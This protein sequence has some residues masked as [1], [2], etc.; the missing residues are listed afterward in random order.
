MARRWTHPIRST[1]H[2]WRVVR[3][4]L[5]WQYLRRQKRF[6]LLLLVVLPVG[7]IAYIPVI[8]L[9]RAMVDHGI[10][11]QTVPLS[12]YL[13][14]IVGLAILA[15]FFVFALTQ[16][17]A[18]VAYQLEYD[19]RTDLYH[20]IQT[21]EVRELDEIAGGQLITRS[22]SDLQIV[23]SIMNLL[24]VALA[25][26]PA[27]FGIGVY[28]F[29][30]SPPLAI[31][32]LLPVP[33]MIKLLRTIRPR[34]AALSWAELNE[35]AEVTT[36]VDEPVRGIRVVKA[37]GRE[38]E[39][40][41]KVAAVSLR[42]YRYTM[43]R[44]RL[45]ARFNLPV[46]ALPVLTQALLLYVG[47]RL[48]GDDHITLGTFL[49]AF[50]L[51]TFTTQLGSGLDGLISTWQYFRSAQD[52]L[53]EVI[54]MGGVSVAA[55]AATAP[56]VAAPAVGD[57]PGITLDDVDV[58][59]DGRLVL[60]GL[61]LHAAPGEVVAV[62]GPP[63]SGKS[64][65]AALACG[66][67]RP[68]H[69]HVLVDG[70]DLEQLDAAHLRQAIRIVGEEPFLFADTLAENLLLG[71]DGDEA[72]LHA[73]LTA[74]AADDVV[75][76]VDGGLDGVLG[77]R[78]LTLSGGQR[79]RVALARALVSPPRVLV[80]DD[81]FSAVNPSL[82][83]EI[84]AHVRTR[85]RR[86]PRCCSSPAAGCRRT[87]PIASCTCHRPPSCSIADAV[88]E[89]AT[90]AE[91]F[92]EVADVSVPSLVPSFTSVAR[93]DLESVDVTT[94][95]PPVPDAAASADHPVGGWEVIR[96]FKW[97][98]LGGIALVTLMTLGQIAPQFAFGSVSDLVENGDIGAVD[99]RVLVLVVV[100]F[101]TAFSAYG[102][103][104]VGQR[105]TQGVLYLFRRR[106]FQRLS[107]LGIDYYDR[108]LPGQVSARL[109][110]DLDILRSF[111][112]DVSLFAI[113]QVAQIVLTFTAILV[114]S[115]SVFPVVLVVAIVIVWLT[116][117]NLPLN[118]RV[119][120]HRARPARSC[121]REVRGGLPRATGDRAD[122]RRRP[123]GEQVPQELLGPAA[124]RVGTCS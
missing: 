115:P 89:V 105:F 94:E 37:F 97:L 102:Y 122:G 91:R 39:E 67:T 109:V 58:L 33:I 63:G 73:A 36:A 5:A 25:L 82:E 14:R 77:D 23:Q 120:E 112:Q 29:V 110:W 16:T 85:T 50:Q 31:V 11:D 19:L 96:R 65:V 47:A 6:L 7:G 61:R 59:F 78:G 90:H 27:I 66:L 52:R 26:G 86:R 24:P 99:V 101:L 57:A 8:G 80:L 38:E 44:A 28:L 121:Q 40:R 114:I 71:G 2:G 17:L 34:L 9:T 124:R 95:R 4:S 92:D 49:I 56:A 70:V 93:H 88:D 62:T 53:R 75:A 100:A 10:V 117:R 76:S 87:S 103:W 32:T 104:I 111:F 54:A 22:L 108:E 1:R 69:G 20:T 21:A 113:T 98:L 60:D 106:Q 43:T 107:R 68:A 30:L 13:W 18:R 55:V 81:A 12:A 46:K 41:T 45:L 119:N 35:R 116:A 118:R 79:Q 72:A 64:T 74:A 83:E 84:F 42:V 48:V 123:P 3:G 51:A 15:G